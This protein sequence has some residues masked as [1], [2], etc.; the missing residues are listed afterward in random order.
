MKKL[1]FILYLLPILAS[2]QMLLETDG[3]KNN[4]KG[5]Q[6]AFEKWSKN[7]NIEQKKGWKW[8]KR[9]ENHYAQ[10]ANTDGSIADPNIFIE[11]AIKYTNRNK[12]KS[13]SS[14][15]PVGPDYLPTSPVST[16]G[17]GVSRINCVTFH[18]TDPNTFWVGVSQGGIW[19]TTNSGASWT[20]M[21]NGLPIL[22]ISDIAIDPISPN[23]L[24]ACLGDYEYIGVALETDDRKRHTHYGVGLYKSTDG[25][26]NWFATGLTSMQ[27]D[28][29]NSLLR[30]VLID[31][32]NTDNILAAGFEGIWKSND[33]GNSWTQKTDTIISDLENH[34]NTPN[35]V[36]AATAFINNLQDGVAGVMKS[37]D[38]GDSWTFLNTGLP[39]T[40]DAQRVEL[41]I[42]P[43]DPNYVYAIAC[44]LSRGF[45]GIYRSTDAGNT[46]SQRNDG[47]STN[48]L[49]WYDGQQGSSGQADVGGQGTYDLTLIV[50]PN[51]KNMLYS[52]GVNCWGSDDGG[53]TWNGA[54]Y[55]VNYYGQ[56][57]HADQHQFKYNILDDKFYVCNDGG[58]MRTDSI[59]IGSW[60]DA[61]NISGYEWPTIWENISDGMQITSFY[62]LGLSDNNPGY[63][64]AGAQDNSTFYLN[65]NNW[66]NIIGG[67]GMECFIHPNQGSTI[68]GSSQYGRLSR[69]YDGGQ[70]IDYNITSPINEEGEWTTPYLYSNNNNAIYAAYENLWRS[71]DDG[72]TWNKISDM[73]DMNGANFSAPASAL[74]QCSKN[75]NVIY[76]AKRIYHSYNS[77]SELWITKNQGN[78]WNNITSG[79]PDSLYFTYIAVDDDNPDI[80]WVTCSGFNSGKKVFRTNNGGQSWINISLNLPNIPV[81]TIVLDEQSSNHT[82]YIGT[83]LGVYFIHDSLSSGWQ[84]YAQ[85]LPNVIISELEIDYITNDLYAAT[86]G[87]GIWKI[88]TWIPTSIYNQNISISNIQINPNPNN[89]IFTINIDSRKSY[90]ATVKIINIMGQTIIINKNKISEGKNTINIKEKDLKSGMYFIEIKDGKNTYTSNFI[91]K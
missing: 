32:N 47:S 48:I 45:H 67:D 12:E 37:T 8:F 15:I 55:W 91:V 63:L 72:D 53:L 14:W 57:I 39:A 83:D 82:V 52:G 56:S 6:K 80:A 29:D 16:S 60:D 24:Y 26:L 43:S 41:A 49:S 2:S 5:L 40:N 42:A 54:S 25:G 71:M 23:I 68:W 50:D 61:D 3:E 27:T 81:N 34:P 44:D 89:G 90:T 64:I 36:F 46:W 13:N 59:I 21:N 70:N 74:A 17:H 9:W 38:F 88:D 58:I 87:R 66:I 33:A 78:T 30:R 20:P 85:D 1:L 31:P 7:N 79:L 10:R 62:R 19:K 86:F 73:N 18:P 76:M 75:Q 69:S 4:F 11:E 65:N 28:L 35:V 84:L 22:R 77:L 51:D